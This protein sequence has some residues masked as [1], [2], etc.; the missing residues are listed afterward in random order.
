MAGISNCLTS[1]LAKQN[2]DRFCNKI[3][4]GALMDTSFQRDED[5]LFV[6]D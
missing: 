1:I 3:A 6:K 4:T 2:K 5:V